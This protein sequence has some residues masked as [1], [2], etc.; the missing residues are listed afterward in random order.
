MKSWIWNTLSS[1]ATTKTSITQHPVCALCGTF[2]NTFNAIH[3]F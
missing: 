3:F 2:N 1:K